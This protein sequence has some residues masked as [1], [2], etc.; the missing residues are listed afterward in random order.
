MG[1]GR[2]DN[3]DWM[4][5]KQS[6]RVMRVM[7]ELSS[8]YGSVFFSLLF[9]QAGRGRERETESL[10]YC[11]EHVACRPWH[12]PWF[13]LAEPGPRRTIQSPIESVNPSF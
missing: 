9:G 11:W 6:V 8:D 1:D 4:G 5:N 2:G 12:V 7:R 13:V 10:S 3:V